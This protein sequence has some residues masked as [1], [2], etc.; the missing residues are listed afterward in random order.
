MVTPRSRS[1]NHQCRHHQMTL[2]LISQHKLQ[3]HVAVLTIENHS[4]RST[5]MLQIPRSGPYFC[6]SETGSNSEGQSEGST[7]HTVS[8]TFSHHPTT[9]TPSGAPFACANITEGC[10][11]AQ[12][13]TDKCG[14]RPQSL[15][16]FPHAS[17]H[18]LHHLP[19]QA[20]LAH[21]QDRAKRRL[22]HWLPSWTLHLQ[23][24]SLPGMHA[25]QLSRSLIYLFHSLYP[26]PS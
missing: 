15:C 14:G 13:S 3:T 6:A 2:C 1:F 25:H 23:N 9:V 10:S 22:H 7:R 18:P 8:P 16:S 24:H 26:T 17:H 4:E 21:S 11:S 5:H 12:H 19:S 20:N